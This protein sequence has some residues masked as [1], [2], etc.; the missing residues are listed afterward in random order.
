MV[1]L[2]DGFCSMTNWR[3][4][5][6]I[7]M[8]HWLKPIAKRCSSLSSDVMTLLSHCTYIDAA[9]W[10][11]PVPVFCRFFLKGV[12]G[13]VPKEWII[14]CIIYFTLPPQTM[15]PLAALE[16]SKLSRSMKDTPYDVTSPISDWKLKLKFLSSYA[17]FLGKI[18]DVLGSTYWF[19]LR[20]TIQIYLTFFGRW[21][22]PFDGYRSPR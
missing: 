14:F 21:I 3:N 1:R 2:N 6:R 19:F 9:A 8:E 13:E 16:S 5:R 17:I 22:F 18:T 15:M 11:I 7:V 10:T 20:N 4:R 12:S